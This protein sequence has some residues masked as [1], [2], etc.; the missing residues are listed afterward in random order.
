[1]FALRRRL[2]EGRSPP[3]AADSFSQCPAVV[4]AGAP[5]ATRA[6]LARGGEA[7]RDV[8]RLSHGHARCWGGGASRPPHP[9]QQRRHLRLLLTANT[10]TGL[11]TCQPTNPE[12][13]TTAGVLELSLRGPIVMGLL[14]VGCPPSPPSLDA[15]EAAARPR[16]PKAVQDLGTSSYPSSCE[17]AFGPVGTE[18]SLG[19]RAGR[20]SDCSR[21]VRMSPGSLS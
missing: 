11:H 18:L 16:E 21:T 7:K 10:C 20:V 6:L 8:L 15:R 19:D 12:S 3:A 4:A 13:T 17:L 5:A 2:G 1:M 14:F 9:C